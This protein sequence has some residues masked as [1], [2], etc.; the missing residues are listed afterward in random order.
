MIQVHYEVGILLVAIHTRFILQF[1]DQ[2]KLLFYRSS[3]VKLSLCQTRKTVRLT[4]ASRRRMK[5]RG[6]FEYSTTSAL[7]FHLM[8]MSSISIQ[9]RVRP[10]SSVGA[11]PGRRPLVAATVSPRSDAL[12]EPA[13]SLK[14]DN[15]GVLVRQS[16]YLV[17]RV[18]IGPT[19]FGL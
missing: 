10:F 9:S 19:T 6:L 8:I 17:A 14:T 13:P 1:P 15:P 16:T 11:G 5:L 12:P 7:V 3:S 18:G 4:S 2:L